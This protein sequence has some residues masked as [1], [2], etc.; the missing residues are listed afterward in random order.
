[1]ID[2]QR[3]DVHYVLSRLPRDVVNAMKTHPNDLF[4]AGGFIRAVIAGEDPNDID[5]WGHDEKFLKAI[6]NVLDAGRAA[7][8]DRT[9]QHMTDNAITLLTSDRLPI[10]AITRWKFE[11]INELVE[12]FDFTIC[13]AAIRWN[14]GAWEGVC[15]NDFYKDLAARRLTYTSPRRVEEAGGSLLRVIKYVQRGYRIQIESLA[16]VVARLASALKEDKIGESWRFGGDREQQIAFVLK[17]L[18]REVDPRL[19]VDGM[20]VIDEHGQET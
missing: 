7:K 17:G 18:L 20:E 19:V 3:Q 10:Q 2:L 14:G 6:I 5:L 1:M 9:K 15:G 11:G 13:Q 12:S 8:G 16:E 4:V